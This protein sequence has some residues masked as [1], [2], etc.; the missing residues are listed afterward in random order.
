MPELPEVET[1]VVGLRELITGHTINEIL[2]RENNI[3]AFPSPVEFKEELLKKT[4][5]GVDRRGKYILIRIEGNKTLVVH[6]RMT[7]K[8]LVKPRKFSFDK[9]THIIFQIDNEMDLRFHNVRK[10][11]RMYLVDSGDYEPAGGLD[12]LG[13]EPL[14]EEF[15]LALFMKKI[16]TRKTNIKSLLLNQSFLAG[17]GNIYVDEALFRAFISPKRKADSLSVREKQN[18]Y[19]AIRSVLQSG[20]ESGGTTFSDYLNV[21]GEKGNFQ[22]Q[23]KV[24]QQED[25]ECPNCGHRIVKEKIAGRGTHYCPNCQR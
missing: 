5:T 24:Y 12:K 25:K 6:L 15:T 20:V 1:I 3:I 10:F 4:I 9:H 18:L 11:G 2:I 14:S 17:L 7:G 16:N 13:P 19:K 23:L 8:L 22:K 21:K